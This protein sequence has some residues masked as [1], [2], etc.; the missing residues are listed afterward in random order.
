V[1]ID[2]FSGIGKYFLRF[3]DVILDGFINTKDYDAIVR[4]YGACGGRADINSDGT[5]NGVDLSFVIY[6]IGRQAEIT[7]SSSPIPQ[8]STKVKIFK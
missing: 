1:H 6:N 5:C 7:A 4:T 3:V 8:K 2:S